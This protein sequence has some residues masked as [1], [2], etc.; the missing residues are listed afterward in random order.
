MVVGSSGRRG[1]LQ[2][3]HDDVI[4]SVPFQLTQLKVNILYIIV[5]IC[6]DLLYTSE[7]KYTDVY[8]FI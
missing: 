3:Q 7:E 5:R 2:V 1:Y 8:L 4:I 6:I